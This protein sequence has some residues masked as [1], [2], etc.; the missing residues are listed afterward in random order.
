[1]PWWP[2]GHGSK[3]RNNLFA[4][5]R[6]RM[7][8]MPSPIHERGAFWHWGMLVLFPFLFG[9]TQQPRRGGRML[10]WPLIYNIQ[11]IV[12]SSC[13]IPFQLP[14][15]FTL[16]ILTN[17]MSP[18]TSSLCLFIELDFS[19]LGHFRPPFSSNINAHIGSQRIWEEL[20]YYGVPKSHIK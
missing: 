12:H 4:Y 18:F 14:I 17:S 5:A 7:H 13:L 9:R 19:K 11:T 15:Y 6:V 20:G 8:T 3:C 2:I 10:V 16:H 1:V